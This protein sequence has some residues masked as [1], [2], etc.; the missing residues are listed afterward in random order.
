[1][2]TEGEDSIGTQDEVGRRGDIARNFKDM[3]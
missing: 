1:M 3:V 2:K